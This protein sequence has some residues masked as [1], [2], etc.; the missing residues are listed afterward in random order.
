MPTFGLVDPDAEPITVVATIPDYDESFPPLKE[1][2]VF[3][4]PTNHAYTDPAEVLA[5]TP[6]QATQDRIDVANVRGEVKLELSGLAD[7]AWCLQPVLVAG[8]D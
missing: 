5:L 4:L 2:H 7:G 8:A 3:A 1:I 6:E